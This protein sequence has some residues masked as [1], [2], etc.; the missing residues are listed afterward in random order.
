MDMSPPLPVDTHSVF[1]RCAEPASSNPTQGRA[2]GLRAALQKSGMTCG[3]AKRR[4]CQRFGSMEAPE[5]TLETHDVS[6][7]EQPCA[8]I[9]D[10]DAAFS[11]RA[12]CGSGSILFQQHR[13]RMRAVEVVLDGDTRQATI[14]HD[15]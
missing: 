5:Y 11:R 14:C 7:H 1:Q 9:V 3:L 13:S 4:Q 8:I 2:A 10:K 15:L 6:D 12:A